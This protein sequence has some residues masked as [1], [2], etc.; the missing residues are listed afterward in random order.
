MLILL[1][2]V[3]RVHKHTRHEYPFVFACCESGNR[4]IKSNPT[5]FSKDCNLN[6]AAHEQRNT[7]A[8][9]YTPFH[10]TAA[11]HHN[12]N[13]SALRFSSRFTI[14]SLI[15]HSM[16]FFFHT[17]AFCIFVRIGKDRDGK[18]LSISRSGSRISLNKKLRE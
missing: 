15:M 10:R 16:L 5:S 4:N 9:R 12:G 17:F 2:P 6:F 7:Y 14:I 3:Q 8:I 11:Y 1:K 13:I 18:S